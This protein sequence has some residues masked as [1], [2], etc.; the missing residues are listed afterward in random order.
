MFWDLEKNYKMKKLAYFSLY[1]L[2][3][4]VC[5]RSCFVFF[6][7]YIFHFSESRISSFLKSQVYEE[8]LK[9]MQNK[10]LLVDPTA[11]HNHMRVFTIISE[12]W[13]SAKLTKQTSLHPKIGKLRLCQSLY[14]RF[15]MQQ[16]LDKCKSK[17]LPTII[18]ISSSLVA[19]F[20]AVSDKTKSW[21]FL[22]VRLYTFGIFYTSFYAFKNY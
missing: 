8:N 1:F 9:K 2:H 16:F 11:N 22:K 19:C 21:T 14:F 7:S 6:Q 13:R 18:E 12:A 3:S 17:H 4:H 5:V 15:D 20:F 10:L